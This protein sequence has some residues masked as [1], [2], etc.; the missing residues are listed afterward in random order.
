MCFYQIA[1]KS[2]IIDLFQKIAD[3]KRRFLICFQGSRNGLFSQGPE[4]IFL[5]LARQGGGSLRCPIRRAEAKRRKPL[6]GLP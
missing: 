3:S 5:S 1:E 6:A 2:G 4:A